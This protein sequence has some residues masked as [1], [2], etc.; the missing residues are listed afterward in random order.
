MISHDFIARQIFHVLNG[1]FLEI[2]YLSEI[3]N[4]ITYLA[5]KK[6]SKG[7]GLSIVFLAII[8]EAFSRVEELNPNI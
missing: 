7:S 2:P 1:F 8:D 3:F 4:K 5:Q 6:N